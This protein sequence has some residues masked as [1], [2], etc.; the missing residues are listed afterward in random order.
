MASTNFIDQSTPIVATWLNDVNTVTYTTVPANTSAIVTNTNNITANTNAISANSSNL[1]ASTGSSLV[2]HTQGGTGTTTTVQAKL[3]QSISVK[4]FGA[5][6]NG[7]TDDTTAIQAAIDYAVANNI[8]TIKV[9]SGT[10]NITSPIRLYDRTALIGD[11]SGTTTI[12]KS[13]TTVGAGSNTARSG[14]VTD[15]YAYDDIIQVIHANNAYAYYVQI[16]GLHLKKTTYATSSHG[17]YYPRTAYVKFEDVWCENVQYGMFTYD[18]FMSSMKNCMMQGVVYG[19]THANDGTGNG[20]GT[21]IVFQNCYVNFDVTTG[22]QPSIGFNL[23]GLSY[24]NLFSCG[25]D[26]G[27]PTTGGITAYYMSTC[28]TINISGCG[29]ENSTGRVIYL[30]SGSAT[31]TGLR[32]YRYTGSS[33]ATSATVWVESSSTLTLTECKFETLLSA[34]VQYNWLINDG[35]QVIEINP[36][37][38]PNG[39]DTFTAYTTSAAKTTITGIGTTK[40]TSAGTYVYQ[41]YPLLSAAPTTGTWAVGNIVYNTAPASA[42]YIGWVCTVAGTPGTWKTF[43]LIS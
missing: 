11:N 12:S 37:S 3:R 4:D 1:A 32:T 40:V 25:V 38:S 35:S 9:P 36:Q 14:S 5:T 20:T 19:Y 18:T 26:N 6:G 28:N 29:T 42:G 34:G 27:K 31:V 13:T 23:F 22:A 2:G 39:G 10:Y 41:A 16:K 17:V 7:T 43:G 33:L 15:S 8:G 30:A 24:S 21:S